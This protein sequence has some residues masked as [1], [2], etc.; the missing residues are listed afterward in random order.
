MVQ[1]S[2]GDRF[3]VLAKLCRYPLWTVSGVWSNC[4]D[5]QWGQISWFQ[6]N[7]ADIQWGQIL[8]GLAKLCR[9]PLGTDLRV[10]GQIVQI[11]YK[12]DF[13]FLTKFC[14]YPVGRDFM[15]WS[16][17]WISSE[18]IR[19]HLFFMLWSVSTEYLQP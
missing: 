12:I 10:L 2:S 15:F 8:G 7:A 16:E 14:R 17:T 19:V 9:Y 5:I 3:Q 13:R 11:S 1:I 4:A 18:D 6:P